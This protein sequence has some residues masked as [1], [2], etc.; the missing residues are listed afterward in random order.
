[1]TG[2]LPKC[3]CI[4]SSSSLS[5]GMPLGYKLGWCYRSTKFGGPRQHA[6][7]DNGDD[8][9]GNDTTLLKIIS[10]H[11]SS[12][13][14]STASVPKTKVEKIPGFHPFSSRCC[15]TKMPTCQYV[16]EADVL[17]KKS[18]RRRAQP[19]CEGLSAS[20]GLLHA[21]FCIGN[22]RWEAQGYWLRL[23]TP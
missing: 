2:Q 8:S 21:V 5:W 19:R 1:M 23:S 16:P 17:C 14:D 7:T 9:V 11:Q 10:G 13:P 18:L 12:R 6:S 3:A 20:G 15:M 4:E 22:L